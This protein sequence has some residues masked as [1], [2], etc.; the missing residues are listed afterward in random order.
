MKTYLAFVILFLSAEA[1]SKSVNIKPQ[2][3]DL[4][5]TLDSSVEKKVTSSLINRQFKVT[6]TGVIVLD[7]FYMFYHNTKPGKEPKTSVLKVK[8]TQETFLSPQFEWKSTRL[9]EKSN[10]TRTS[11]F[12]VNNKELL[13]YFQEDKKPVKSKKIAYKENILPIN[14]MPYYLFYQ[15]RNK[16]GIPTDLMVFSEQ[17]QSV[18]KI[19]WVYL[20]TSFE[21]K[22]R[23]HRFEIKGGLSQII[24]LD[25]DGRILK[26]KDLARHY[27]ISNVL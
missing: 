7:D 24:H 21:N 5:L 22:K 12:N 26:I 13:V 9:I 19:A 27:I 14:A 1:F 3:Q 10:V 6:P 16:I 4:K 18:Q 15:G 23:I 11:Q 20:G 8:Y 2:S 25:M 17:N